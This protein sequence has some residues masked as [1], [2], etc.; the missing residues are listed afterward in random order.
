VKGQRGFLGR[1]LLPVDGDGSLSGLWKGARISALR[2]STDS[3][4]GTGVL[5]KRLL[6]KGT[7]STNRIGYLRAKRLKPSPVTLSNVY[8]NM[9]GH[10]TL[11][12]RDLT[13][14]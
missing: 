11:A 7:S 10:T 14:E 1:L 13:T 4:R 3:A 8:S 9:R 5:L 6:L 2:L 12:L